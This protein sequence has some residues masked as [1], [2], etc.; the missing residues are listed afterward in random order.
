MK[1]RKQA[2][3]GN[4]PQS[5]IKVHPADARTFIAIAA[6]HTLSQAAESLGLQLHTVS[7]CLKRLECS[8]QVALV[9]RSRDGLHLSETGHRFLVACQKFWRHIATPRRHCGQR[10]AK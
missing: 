5:T 10:R 7:R 8:A 6:S 1:K 2:F 9:R 3:P 4:S